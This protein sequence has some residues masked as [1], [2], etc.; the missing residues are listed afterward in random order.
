MNRPAL[1]SLI[2]S[3]QKTPK[4]GGSKRS[5]QREIIAKIFG[6]VDRE[7]EDS[8]PLVTTRGP[9]FSSVVSFVSI[10]VHSWSN[11]GTVFVAEPVTLTAEV[12]SSVLDGQVLDASNEGK[13]AL[14]AAIAF[15]APSHGEVGAKNIG[16]TQ[17]L[18]RR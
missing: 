16:K 7:L 4:T 17:G 8:K 15:I 12:R 6:G 2:S 5:G 14:A 18:F 13:G 9:V 1:N 3:Q 10:R 11:C